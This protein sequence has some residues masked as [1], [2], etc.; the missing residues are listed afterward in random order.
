MSY[1]AEKIIKYKT[2]SGIFYA[3]RINKILKYMFL[4]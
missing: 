2:P 3:Q 1:Y 4:P